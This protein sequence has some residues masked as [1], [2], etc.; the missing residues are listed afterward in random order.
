M[1]KWY[2]SIPSKQKQAQQLFLSFNMI[3]SNLKPSS[4]FYFLCEGREK[5]AFFL[6]KKWL[7]IDNY[8]LVI[9][10][11]FKCVACFNW[12]NC[13]YCWFS[14]HLTTISSTKMNKKARIKTIYKFR[15]TNICITF[16]ISFMFT[17]Y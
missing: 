10:M 12:F 9:D 4:I 15:N 5:R 13:K 7:N 11:C 16:C 14:W 2:Q 3:Y 8:F 17:N 1:Q 6:I